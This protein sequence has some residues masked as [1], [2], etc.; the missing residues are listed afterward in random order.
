MKKEK[1]EYSGPFYND[2]VEESYVSAK[3]FAEFLLGFLKVD[4][5]ID[6]GC[7]VGTWTGAFRDCGVPSVLGIDGVYVDRNQLKIDSKNFVEHDLQQSLPIVEPVDLA[8]CV[9]VAEHLTPDRATSFI[10]DLCRISPCVLFSAAAP[11]QGG[12]YHLNEQ[13]PEYWTRIF[14]EQ[15][16][17]C[18]DLFR[19]KFWFNQNV[20]YYYKQNAFLYCKDEVVEKLP[21]S[22]QKQALPGNE[23]PLPIIHPDKWFEKNNDVPQYTL[24]SWFLHGLGHV[25]KLPQVVKQSLGCRWRG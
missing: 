12:L 13:W 8:V 2:Y 11:Y 19:T 16:Y 4:S 20:A 5:L 22:V 6:V 21:V 3:C 18:L 9:E 25:A 23:Y 7:G 24:K 15:G 10:A 14:Y 1:R 17:K